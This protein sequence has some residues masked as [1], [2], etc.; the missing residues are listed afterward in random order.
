MQAGGAGDWKVAAI[1]A[2]ISAMSGDRPGAAA[3]R[4]AQVTDR[5]NR[6]DTAFV[7][8]ARMSRRKVW[9]SSYF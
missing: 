6:M 8:I 7:H 2:I 3:V 4:A 9:S 5:A 1:A